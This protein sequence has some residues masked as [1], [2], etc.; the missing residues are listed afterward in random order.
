MLPFG[1]ALAGKVIGKEVVYHIH[2]ISV[3]PNLLKRFLRFIIQKTATKVFFVSKVFMELE[4]FENIEQRV[5]YNS[6]P[7]LFMQ[8]AKLF[9]YKV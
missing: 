8:D 3:S 9:Q 5:I 2:E 7:D 1:A 6:L 4:P